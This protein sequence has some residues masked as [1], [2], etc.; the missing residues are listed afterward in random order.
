MKVEVKG[1]RK[2]YF[3]RKQELK[4]LHSLSPSLQ[5]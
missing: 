5:S 1:N 2:R 3:W 4:K